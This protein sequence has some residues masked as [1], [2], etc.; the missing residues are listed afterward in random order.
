LYQAPLAPVK[1]P[2]AGQIV[3]LWFG[4]VRKRDKKQQADKRLNSRSSYS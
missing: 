1:L 3:Q 2:L 4:E